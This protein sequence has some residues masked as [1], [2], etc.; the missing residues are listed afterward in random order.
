[1]KQP[2][3]SPMIKSILAAILSAGSLCA[4]PAVISVADVGAKQETAPRG[5]HLYQP[6]GVRVHHPWLVNVNGTVHLFHLNDVWH[7][8]SQDCVHWEPDRAILPHSAFT[9]AERNYHSE[10]D[11][12]T[13]CAVQHEGKIF[14]FWTGNKGINQRFCNRTCWSM[15]T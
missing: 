7:A 15:I 5:T 4:A 8:T 12:W 11:V 10:Q 3:P 6:T 1:M 13:G 14:L 9:A 2:L